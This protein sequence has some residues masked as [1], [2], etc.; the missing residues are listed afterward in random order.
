MGPGLRREPR[1]DGSDVSSGAP[2][3]LPVPL[4]L[5]VDIGGGV[6]ITP[7]A[8]ERPAVIADLENYVSP[9]TRAVLVAVALFR[10]F[11][12]GPYP[13]PLLALHRDGSGELAALVE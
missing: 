9:I 3:L 11:G 13:F 8:G 4:R 5:E 2:S 6:A 7:F 10:G 1:G 12:G